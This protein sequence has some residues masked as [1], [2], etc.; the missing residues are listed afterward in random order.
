MVK[1]VIYYINDF[2]QIDTFQ[3]NIKIKLMICLEIRTYVP[4]PLT[5]MV[6]GQ[7][8]KTLNNC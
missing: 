5:V 1:T 3:L 6:I 8:H 2:K 7:N 4:S